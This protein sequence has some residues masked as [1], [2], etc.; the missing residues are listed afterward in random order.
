M[1]RLFKIGQDRHDYGRV[2]FS[3]NPDGNFIASAGK[4][5]IIQI[6]DRHGDIVDEIPMSNNL[7]VTGLEWDK[8]GDCL[9]ILQEGSGIIPLWSLST[10]RVIPLETSFKDPSFITWSRTSSHLAVGMYHF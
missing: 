1:K 8:D 7:P 5:S 9:A 4:N 10:R 3:W 6:T 2:I